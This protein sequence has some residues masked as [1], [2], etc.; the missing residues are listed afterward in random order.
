MKRISADW[1]HPS[2]PR[3]GVKHLTA[4]GHPAF[5]C[6]E[7]L[8]CYLSDTWEDCSRG[9][10]QTRSWFRVSG[11]IPQVSSCSAETV[12]TPPMHTWSH[13]KQPHSNPPQGL[14]ERRQRS[15]RQ[16]AGLRGGCTPSTTRRLP[17]RTPV[18]TTGRK[19]GDRAESCR[20]ATAGLEASAPDTLR[21]LHREGKRQTDMEEVERNGILF[22]FCQSRREEDNSQTGMPADGPIKPKFV[23]CFLKR[24]EEF[25]TKIPTIPSIHL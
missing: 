22:N 1:F 24:G 14:A 2:V 23:A 5:T 6:M 19:E 25:S 10:L 4:E 12:H 7:L 20:M 17:D 8:D 13:L 3:F 18:R 9:L 11:L 21:L 16:T 15:S